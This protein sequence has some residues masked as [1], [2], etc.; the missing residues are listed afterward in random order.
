MYVNHHTTSEDRWFLAL[1]AAYESGSSE[2][3]QQAGNELLNAL[4]TEQAQGILA[5]VG[6]QAADK[7]LKD[8]EAL[9]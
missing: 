1:W 4:P 2:A 8:L 7:A 3:L 9:R 6:A 5:R